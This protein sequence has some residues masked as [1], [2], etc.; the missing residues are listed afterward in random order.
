MVSSDLWHAGSPS[1]TAAIAG[2]THTNTSS[3]PAATSNMLMLG[4]LERTAYSSALVGGNQPIINYDSS[5]PMTTASSS[6]MIGSVLKAAKNT[7][8]SNSNSMNPSSSQVF[9]K[10]LKTKSE[11]TWVNHKNNIGGSLNN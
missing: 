7:V 6:T 9:S 10:H 1:L 2:N 3:V 5:R 11:V 4:S 8:S